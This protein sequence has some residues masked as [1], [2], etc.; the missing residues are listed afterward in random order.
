MSNDILK[1]LYLACSS[2]V[3]CFADGRNLCELYERIAGVKPAEDAYRDYLAT[4]EAEEKEKLDRLVYPLCDLRE[5]QG[6]INGFR[7]GMKLAGELQGEELE[8]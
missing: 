5:M 4:V 2:G 3:D 7:L 6:F 8:P 1:R